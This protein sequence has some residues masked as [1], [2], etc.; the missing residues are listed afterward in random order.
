MLAAALATLATQ[1]ECEQVVGY[2]LELIAAYDHDE[3]EPMLREPCDMSG[4]SEG[5]EGYAK[6][7]VED[8]ARA[9]GLHKPELPFCNTKQDPN[10]ELDPW[11]EKGQAVLNA[12]SAVPL[13]PRWHQWVGITKMMDNMFDGKN[14]LVMDEVGVGK[15]FQ[16][17]GA[18]TMFE[19]Q[20]LHF[21]QFKHFS[22]R[23]GESGGPPSCMPTNSVA[24]VD[25]K[26]GGIKLEADTHLIVVPPGLMHQWTQELHRYLKRGSF[27][28]LPYTGQCTVNSRKAFWGLYA[29]VA[30]PV[31]ILASTT[32]SSPLFIS[33]C[34]SCSHFRL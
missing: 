34:R 9:L 21:Q 23:F 29:S 31:I 25:H 26:L 4:W 33:V 32:V 30:K 18:I 22:S 17:V 15:S 2:V 6:L 14:L 7:A 13:S 24:A 8:L 28:V 3:D 5:V 16:A 11:T 12:P 19:Y 1:A 20:R 27:S 10:G